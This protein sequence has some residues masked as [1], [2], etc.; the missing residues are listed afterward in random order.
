M[1]ALHIFHEPSSASVSLAL[2]SLARSGTNHEHDQPAHLR[3]SDEGR[4]AMKRLNYDSLA[5]GPETR[6]CPA[7]VYEWVVDDDELSSGGGKEEGGEGLAV[8]LVI[9]AQNCLHCKVRCA[10]VS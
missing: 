1:R 10:S 9:N 3:V 2:L 8:K 6:Y 5:G 4:A 7:G